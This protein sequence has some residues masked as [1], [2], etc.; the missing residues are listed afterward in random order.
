MISLTGGTFLLKPLDE[1]GSVRLFGSG[2]IQV[3]QVFLLIY[4]SPETKTVGHCCV[5]IHHHPLVFKYLEDST[6]VWPLSYTHGKTPHHRVLLTLL[7]NSGR[8]SKQAISSGFF[9]D[10]ISLIGLSWIK[11]RTLVWFDWQGTK[12]P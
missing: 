3:E 1:S 5:E 9:S 11:I 10:L 7:L 6:S 12:K 8:F 2:F 4:W